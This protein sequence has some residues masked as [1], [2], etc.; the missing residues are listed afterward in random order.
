MSFVSNLFFSVEEVGAC[1]ELSFARQGSQVSCF[2]V[3]FQS[4]S[5]NQRRKF[6]LFRRN[7]LL[8]STASRLNIE[9]AE[10][11]IFTLRLPLILWQWSSH[12][13]RMCL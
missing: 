1:R 2:L 10:I 9:N 8:F 3:A 13:S 4:F 5:W 6:N 7:F 11:R 12:V